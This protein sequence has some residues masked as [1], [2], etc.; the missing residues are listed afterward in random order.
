MNERDFLTLAQ[1]LAVGATE[2]E[3]R[4]AVSRA[5][6]AAFHVARHLLE[7]LGF[8]VPQADRA[9]AYLWLRLYNCGDAQVQAAGA[10]LNALRRDR[11]WADY[12]LPRPLV[13]A[14]AQARLP[15]T[16]RII[17]ILDAAALEPTRTQITDAMRIYERDV[18]YDVTWHP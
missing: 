18:L 2:A 1:R 10:D 15:D 4:S 3:W 8:T 6:Y 14:F 11:N 13:Q 12:N 16:E 7:D 5:Y 9:H 17:Q